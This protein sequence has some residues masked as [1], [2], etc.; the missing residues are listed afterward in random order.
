L[1]EQEQTSDAPDSQVAVYQFES[2][3]ATWEHRKFAANKVE[4]SSVGCY[5]YGTKG[6]FH[7]GWR[8]GWTFYPSDDRGK[9][10]H[11]NAQ[12]QEPDGHNLKLLWQDFL[13]SI[14]DGRSPAANV[15]AGHRASTLSLL[16]MLSLNVGRS[17][18]WNGDKEVIVGDAEASRLL[19]RPYRGPWQYPAA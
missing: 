1:T 11:E 10:I 3:T 17:I 19:S 15:E 7:M 9:V 8:D 5:F 2:F 18:E 14:R 4:K 16:G 13:E 6:T 12:I